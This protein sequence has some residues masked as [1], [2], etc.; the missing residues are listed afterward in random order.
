MRACEKAL[1]WAPVEAKQSG[2]GTGF[3]AIPSRTSTVLGSRSTHEIGG[4]IWWPHT[5]LQNGIAG[6]PEDTRTSSFLPSRPLT[7]ASPDFWAKATRVL[8]GTLLGAYERGVGLE[9]LAVAEAQAARRFS[10]ATSAHTPG[11]L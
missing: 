8:L 11:V 3:S 6:A 5:Q 1:P 10:Q 7:P 4:A 9:N 2:R